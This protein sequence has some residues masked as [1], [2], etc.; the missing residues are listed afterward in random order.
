MRGDDLLPM[1]PKKSKGRSSTLRMYRLQRGIDALQNLQHTLIYL[2]CYFS[3]SAGQ[4]LPFNYCVSVRAASASYRSPQASV[5]GKLASRHPADSPV[6]KRRN[7]VFE[8]TFVVSDRSSVPN[9][10]DGIPL[11]LHSLSVSHCHYPTHESPS[12]GSFHLALCVTMYRCT[13]WSARHAFLPLGSFQ[14]ATAR[15]CHPPW[16]LSPLP[17]LC[18][19]AS[20]HA[21]D[22]ARAASLPAILYGRLALPQM[23]PA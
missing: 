14:P 7:L 8:W 10:S 21:L 16:L 20:S 22:F 2:R 6:A 17:W 23:C 5:P 4:L 9:Q 3:P 15:F 12:S 11:S 18:C 19:L 1:N 13:L